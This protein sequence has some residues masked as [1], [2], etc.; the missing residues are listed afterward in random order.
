MTVITFPISKSEKSP[1]QIQ[2]GFLNIMRNGLLVRVFSLMV[3]NINSKVNRIFYINMCTL[4]SY[5][6][7]FT[8]VIVFHKVSLV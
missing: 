2:D 4:F 7:F 6:I 5:V 1:P 3:I 8:T